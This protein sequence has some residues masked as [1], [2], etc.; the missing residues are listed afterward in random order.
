MQNRTAD[1]SQPPAYVKNYRKFRM[2]GFWIRW[3]FFS[4]AHNNSC[5]SERVLYLIIVVRNLVMATTS[6]VVLPLRW[7]EQGVVS[8]EVHVVLGPGR[9]P[10]GPAARHV[11][12][13]L[14]QEDQEQLEKERIILGGAGRDGRDGEGIFAC[15]Y[16]GQ[17]FV[18][19]H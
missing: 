6:S 15:K 2:E 3:T 12:R 4:L 13:I 1:E 5:H 19:N 16:C 18:E 14:C 7:P 11:L 10:R 8:F 9:P 17:E